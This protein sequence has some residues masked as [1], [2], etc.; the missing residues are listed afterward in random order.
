M[1]ENIS[2]A[3][4]PLDIRTPGQFIEFDNTRA[5]QGLPTQD[6]KILVIGNRLAAGDV[7]AEIP[8]RILNPEQGEAAFGRGSILAA[9][10][11][12]VK[13]ANRSTD[14]W[15][16]ALDDADAGVAATGS[17]LFAGTPTKAQT[18]TL[19]V[20]GERVQIALATTDTAA[21]IATKLVAQINAQTDL[22]L[23]AAVNGA[24]PAKVDLTARNKGE[25]GNDID[26]RTT[27]Y[28]T[29]KQPEGITVTIT[30]MANGDG[31]P[32]IA[33]ALAAVGDDQ[34]YTIL[35]PWTDETNMAALEAELTQRWGPMTQKT[36]HAF[37][38][39]SATHAGLSTYG[40]SRNSVQ[41]SVIG[42]HNSPTAPWV[43]ASAWAAVVEFNGAIDPARP[44]QTLTLPGVMAPPEESR[45]NREERNILLKDGISTLTVGQD[46]TVYIER[47][48]TTY[49]Q[50]AFGVDDISYLNLNTKWTVDYIRYAVRTRIALRFP[51][52]K[53]ADDG[54]RFAPGQAVVTP[55]MIRA[56]L[57]ALFRELEQV[58]LVEDFEQFKA[59][60]LVVR[61]NSDPDRVNAIIPPNIVNQ[62]RVFAAAV[63]F[64]L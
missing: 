13:F 3:E 51:R 58:A 26:L 61:S 30:A 33:D 47:V 6:R 36:G 63:Q 59:D 11:E 23:I 12:A 35:S 60:L 50:N 19:Y 22:P 15:A 62:F 45:F 17:I 25:H 27:Y 55:S 48:I 49:Q 20:A 64:L 16:V 7:A 57:L 38:G 56:E 44:F 14:V 5:V 8:V 2:F 32:D 31:N 10:L 9:M 21:T 24:T 39:L 18:M 41:S 52:F 46:G 37:V 53:L 4:I 40:T 42:W 54:T 43:L 29:D 28:Q 34:F 1:A